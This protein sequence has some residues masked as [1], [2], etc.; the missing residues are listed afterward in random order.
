MTLTLESPALPLRADSDG[1][2]RVGQTR[3]TLATVVSA[4]KNGATAE[5]IAYDYSSLDLADIYAVIHFYLRRRQQVDDYLAET[6][7]KGEELRKQLEAGYDS[8]G[9]RERLL[10]RRNSKE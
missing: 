3:V 1:V 4:F 9:I 5:Q 7:R 2:V 6:R 8:Q 10:V